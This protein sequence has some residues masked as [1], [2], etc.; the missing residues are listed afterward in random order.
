MVYIFRKILKNIFVKHIPGRVFRHEKTHGNEARFSSE[1]EANM[2]IEI[3]S[4]PI[5]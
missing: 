1:P 3:V 5:N 4:F 2:A